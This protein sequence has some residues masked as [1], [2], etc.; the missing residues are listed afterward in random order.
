M[1]IIDEVLTTTEAARRWK[2]SQVTVKQACSGQ[3]G[4][5]PRF[6]TTECRK[7]GSTWLVTRQGMIRLY[8]EEPK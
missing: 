8:G 5:P 1:N 3:K 6:T 4:Y 7:S 2:V